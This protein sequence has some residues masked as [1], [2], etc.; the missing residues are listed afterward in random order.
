MA[1]SKRDS[2]KAMSAGLENSLPYRTVLWKSL[3]EQ[4]ATAT[5]ASEHRSVFWHLVSSSSAP[6]AHIEAESSD[7]PLPVVRPIT[8]EDLRE[9]EVPI[10][11][12]I[13]AKSQVVRGFGAPRKKHIRGEMTQKPIA[14]PLVEPIA[15]EPKE[16]YDKLLR[17]QKR[18]TE[19]LAALRIQMKDQVAIE[20]QIRHPHEFPTKTPAPTVEKPKPPTPSATATPA[21]PNWDF[22]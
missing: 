22:K 10:E 15:Q 7:P 14:L 21:K 16:H 1:P 12:S 19:Q 20:G 2:L 11:N 17:E 4:H 5:I 3:L 9:A 6:V 8:E 13:H 18:V